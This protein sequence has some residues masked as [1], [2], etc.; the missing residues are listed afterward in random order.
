ME[1]VAALGDRALKVLV[2]SSFAHDP[3][4]RDRLLSAQGDR[5]IIVGPQPHAEMPLYLAAADLVA[6][7][8]QVC[9]VTVAQVP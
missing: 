2:V 5:L 6:L 8:Q 7:P 1:A 4:Y 3:A 9:R